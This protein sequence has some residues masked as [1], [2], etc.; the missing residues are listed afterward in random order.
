MSSGFAGYPPKNPIPA[1]KAKFE[2]GRGNDIKSRGLQVRTQWHNKS[3]LARLE[4]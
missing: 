1:D 3:S 2:G 4:G